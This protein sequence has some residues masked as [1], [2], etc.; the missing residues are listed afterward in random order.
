MVGKKRSIKGKKSQN[1]LKEQFPNNHM[2]VKDDTTFQSFLDLQKE[3]GKNKLQE[4]PTPEK[5]NN[6]MIHKPNVKRYFP[7]FYGRNVPTLTPKIIKYLQEKSKIIS[8]SDEEL[9]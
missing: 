4:V 3:K 5:G 1:K 8:L 7:L 2:E 6:K 9:E